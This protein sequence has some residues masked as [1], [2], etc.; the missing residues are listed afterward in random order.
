MR[1]GSAVE[2]SLCCLYPCGPVSLIAGPVLPFFRRSRDWG[3]V[4][5]A[6]ST[7][8]FLNGVYRVLKILSRS[9]HFF[10]SLTVWVLCS[11]QRILSRSA[12]PLAFLAWSAPESTA[13]VVSKAFQGRPSP[14]HCVLHMEHQY[15]PPH[16]LRG[17]RCPFC[18]SACSEHSLG[19]LT[20]PP[21][22]S[23]HLFGAQGFQHLPSA[24]LC[25]QC[26]HVL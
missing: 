1:C 19:P 15:S 18:H 24:I 23:A 11:S 26:I 22:C 7:G 25:L 9:G 10:V 12:T 20:G 8:N 13:R 2:A 5:S 4:R 17:F 3:L 6:S 16:H 21:S 14:Q